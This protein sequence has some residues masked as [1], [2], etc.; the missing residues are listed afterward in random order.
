MILT[1]CTFFCHSMCNNS[2]IHMTHLRNYG[3][4]GHITRHEHPKPEKSS[5]IFSTY[6]HLK[7]LIY[8]T[9]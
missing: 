8:C 7:M 5:Y 9:K 1:K 6:Y 4:L 3:F 2:G